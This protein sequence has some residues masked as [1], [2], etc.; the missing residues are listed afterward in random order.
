[1]VVKRR[2]AEGTG[3]F[4]LPQISMIPHFLFLCFHIATLSIMIG[5]DKDAI[6]AVTPLLSVMGNSVLISISS[7]DILISVFLF[8]EFSET[9]VTWDHQDLGNTRRC[10]TKFSSLQT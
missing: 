4:I 8:F 10:S 1:M 3:Q 7:H 5:G 9:S 2:T 6:T